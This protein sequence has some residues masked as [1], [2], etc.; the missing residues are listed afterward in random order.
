MRRAL[1]F[2]AALALVVLAG[3]AP[4]ADGP[5]ITYTNRADRFAINLPGQPRVEEFTYRSEMGSPWKARRYSV[6]HEGYTYRTTVVDMSTNAVPAQAGRE[7][8]G[9]IAF[10]AAGLRKTGRV[11]MDTYDQ[12]Q[13]IPG[14]KLEIVLPDGSLNLIEL[15]THYNLL[16]ITEIISPKDAVPGY[17]V[18]SSL[19]L[20]GP[21]GDVPRYEDAGFPGPIPVASTE[22][23][24]GSYVK[25]QDRFAVNFPA[26][27]RVEEFVFTSAQ[28]S[29][30]KAR[31]YVAE[32]DGF[33]YSLSV[34]DTSTTSLT[35]D[36]DAFR[37]TARPGSERGG[38]IAFA[39][40]NVRKSGTVTTDSYAERQVIPGY[41]I[42]VTL[43][44][45]RRNLAEIYQHDK[46][47]YL[48]EVTAPRGANPA[49]AMQASLQMLD[50]NGNVPV[51]QDNQRTFPDLAPRARGGGGPAGDAAN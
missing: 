32:A 50:A 17:D 5:W 46:L 30:W 3:P 27:P 15:H 23:L 41:R 40:W 6:A 29:P 37:N 25:R 21:Q 36:N 1:L 39:A 48:W 35:P 38:A 8:R 2:S 31:R 34:V 20:M 7:K 26:P 45:G 14:H 43:P 49:N 12:L 51:Y 18:Q 22:P 19:E 33:R 4:A 47:F 28:G 16:Y 42:E 13:V 11:I 10:A 24:R 44:D 9:A